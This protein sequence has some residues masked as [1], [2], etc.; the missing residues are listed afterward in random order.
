MKKVFK[1][2]IEAPDQ[3]GGPILEAAEVREIFGNIPPIYETHCVIKQH[4][5]ELAG[6]IERNEEP[7]L[8][9]EIYLKQVNII[10]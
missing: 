9:G 5:E 3:S 4:L 7:V 1:E 8:V 10:Q 2:P 6:K